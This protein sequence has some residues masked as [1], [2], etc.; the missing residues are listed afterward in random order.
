MRKGAL[1][2]RDVELL[3]GLSRPLGLAGDIEPIELYVP[4][5]VL[6]STVM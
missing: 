6:F 4:S 3:K 1:E 5:S 2:S